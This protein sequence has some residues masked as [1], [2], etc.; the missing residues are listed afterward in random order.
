MWLC[1]AVNNNGM[2]QKENR[3]SRNIPLTQILLCDNQINSK[4]KYNVEIYYH[5]NLNGL[6]IDL[7]ASL[8]AK[9]DG[10]V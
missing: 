3:D 7:S 1:A 4:Y 6:D 8:N 10:G 5:S 2:S 9:C